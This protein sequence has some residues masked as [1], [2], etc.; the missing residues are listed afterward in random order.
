MLRKMGRRKIRGA[1]RAGGG[2]VRARAR[3]APAHAPSGVFGVGGTL[4]SVSAAVAP[5]GFPAPVLS[6]NHLRLSCLLPATRAL[7]TSAAAAASAA[8]ADDAVLG[9][10]S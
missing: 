7:R 1:A 10:L 4:A 2:S 3:L 8:V 9:T 6:C 5:W